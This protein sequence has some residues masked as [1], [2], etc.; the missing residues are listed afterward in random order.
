[1][2]SAANSSRVSLPARSG[3]KKT[4]EEKP[5]CASS[6]MRSVTWAGVPVKPPASRP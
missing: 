4:K 5:A 1:M 2:T 6:P 3:V